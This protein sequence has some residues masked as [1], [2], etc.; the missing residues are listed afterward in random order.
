MAINGQ[1]ARTRRQEPGLI[2]E[3]EV[4]WSSNKNRHGAS[5][6]AEAVRLPVGRAA[7]IKAVSADKHEAAVELTQLP[8]VELDPSSANE[9]TH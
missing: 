6:P 5:C 2:S 1:N 4:R 9:E 3:P 8:A 7:L